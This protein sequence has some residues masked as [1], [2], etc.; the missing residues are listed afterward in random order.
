MQT[1]MMSCHLIPMVHE[2]NA[3]AYDVMMT[4]FT[5]YNYMETLVTPCQACMMCAN[6]WHTC[7]M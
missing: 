5:Y 3:N 4:W 2:W 1:L 7:S 6:E